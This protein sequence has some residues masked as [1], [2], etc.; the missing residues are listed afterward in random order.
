MTKSNGTPTAGLA[1]LLG[2]HVVLPGDA[3]YDE[4]RQAFNLTIDQR[5]AA[6]VQ[7]R[8]AADVA[9]TV[10]FAAAN[11]LRV[12]PQ[13]TGHNAGPIASLAGTILLRTGGMRGV[14]IDFGAGT[15][16][17]QAGTQW[18]EVADPASEAGLAP[19]AGSSPNVGVVGYTLGGG[20]GWLTRK[21]GLASNHVRSI[22]LVTADGSQ[23]RVDAATDP[24]LFW[25]LRGGGGSY[26]VVTAMEFDLVPVREIYAGALFFPFERA[27][28]VLHAWREWAATV[29]D[30]IT[31]VGRLMQ[32]PPMEEIPD[33]MRGQSFAIVEAAA[34]LDEAAGATALAPLRALGPAMDTFA[35]V[36]PAA[37]GHLHMDPEHPVPAASGA[38]ALLGEIPAST[39]DDVVRIAGPGTDSP[40]LSFE[41][42]HLGGAAGRAKPGHGALAALPGEFATFAVGI[43]FDPAAAQAIE[44]RTAALDEALAPHVAGQYLNF[45]EEPVATATLFPGPVH[46]R[47]AAIRRRVDPDGLIVANHAIDTEPSTAGA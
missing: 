38:Y 47:L 45:V 31:S 10:E 26:G 21:H 22:D 41:I 24:D 40:L 43:P 2:G 3:G 4:A 28:E 27:A 8:S 6:V 37:L 35:M 18:A 32:F 29:P 1:G 7:P 17:V 5:P 16:R 33:P 34:L 13:S 12:A 42:R 36:P 46:D 19:L 20:V 11:G 25:A 15:A 23:L 39:I 30:E 44:G 9:A 14:E